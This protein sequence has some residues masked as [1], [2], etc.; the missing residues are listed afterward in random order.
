[1]HEPVIGRILPPD[2]AFAESFHDIAGVELYPEE[3]AAVTQAVDNR[4]REFSTVRACARDAMRQLGHAA[5]PIPRGVHG[6]PRWPDGLV[7]SMTHC[8]GY[9]AAAV[10]GSHVICALGIDAEPHEPLPAGVATLIGRA[11]ELASMA[12]RLPDLCCSR[13]L[14]SAKESAYKA[15]FPMTGRWLG[16]MDAL[17][18]FDPAGTFTARI[19]LA[20]S[21]IRRFH[22]RWVVSDGLACTS[23]AVYR[24]LALA[25]LDT[26][27]HRRVVTH[28]DTRRDKRETARRA[29]LPQPGAAGGGGCWVR[30]R[31]G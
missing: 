18:T 8:S 6:A 24:A 31:V 4:K 16:F 22:G 11:D 25:P 2:V 9:R 27:M 5:A 1:M 15:W 12:A 17:V 7:G 13:L 20:D 19:L 28:R 14:F 30:T 3:L 10:A 21:P 23:V 26:A 29:A